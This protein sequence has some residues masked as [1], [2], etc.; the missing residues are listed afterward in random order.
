MAHVHRYKTCQTFQDFSL[1]F[2]HSIES[3]V[4]DCAEKR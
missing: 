2:L 1:D 4:T 3:T